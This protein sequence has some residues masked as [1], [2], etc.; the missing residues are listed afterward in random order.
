MKKTRLLLVVVGAV[1]VAKLLRSGK[2]LSWET[3]F[4]KM[5][6][7]APPKWMYLNISAIRQQNDRIIEL[8]EDKPTLEDAG[9]ATGS[10]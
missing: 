2:G 5:P 4:E 8:L 10:V 7:D 9:E 3:I 6:D 1:M